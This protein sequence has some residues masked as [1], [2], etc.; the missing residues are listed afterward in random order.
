MKAYV[1]NILSYGR[2][3]KYSWYFLKWGMG[4]SV[5]I[6][7]FT[8]LNY[9]LTEAAN[10]VDPVSFFLR[11]NAG[12]LSVVFLMMFVNWGL[13]I[14]KWR[15][16]MESIGGVSWKK[17]LKTILTGIY[18]SAFTP[19]RTGD[20]FGRL[21]H[22]GAQ[23]RSFAFFGTFLC[24]LAQVLVTIGLGALGLFMLIH[25]GSSEAFFPVWLNYA[26]PLVIAFLL[27]VYL[28]VD[29]WILRFP[30]LFKT[31]RLVR[32]IR[33]GKVMESQKIRIISLALFRYGIYVV[34]PILLFYAAG[35]DIP[36][37]SAVCGISILYLFHTLFPMPMILQVATKTELALL[38]WAPF[39][40]DPALILMCM[41]MVWT[42]NVIL[43][44]IP[45]FISFEFK[46]D[47]N[48]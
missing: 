43:M 2:N 45:G 9:K 5:A 30:K 6:L 36:F 4:L 29:K 20:Y 37:S 40:P 24:S 27:T 14:M 18:F 26:L 46:H 47:R 48:T 19:A 22:V 10:W 12:L 7:L 13:E 1:M 44:A 15:T 31:F 3:H 35:W 32:H 23:D 16:V 28:K 11:L 17:A 42:M 25:S 34:Q 21:W 39:N 38:I 33:E 41:L 8:Q